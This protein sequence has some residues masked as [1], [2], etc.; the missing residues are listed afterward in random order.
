MTI[1]S[2]FDLPTRDGLEKLWIN[3]ELFASEKPTQSTGLRAKGMKISLG[4]TRTNDTYGKL[5]LHMAAESGEQY[6]SL[7]CF[8]SKCEFNII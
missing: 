4:R 1:S 7:S 8:L 5:M 6:H 3:F 2:E